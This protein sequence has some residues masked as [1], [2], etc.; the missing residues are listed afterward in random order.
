MASSCQG[1][2]LAELAP[3]NVILWLWPEMFAECYRGKTLAVA[4]GD[5]RDADIYLLRFSGLY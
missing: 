5:N 2:F 1:F 3:G 4:V